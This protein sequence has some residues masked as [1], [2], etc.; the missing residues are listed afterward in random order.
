MVSLQG[1][2]NQSI[3]LNRA[4]P[5]EVSVPWL[6]ERGNCLSVRVAKHISGSIAFQR[7]F[8]DNLLVPLYRKQW[9]ILRL[10]NLQRQQPCW[11]FLLFG[12]AIPP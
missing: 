8:L 4:T 7:F 2:L 3:V 1:H 10:L 5:V 9:V 6:I 12:N 11:R